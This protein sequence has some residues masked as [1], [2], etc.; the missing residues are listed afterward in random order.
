MFRETANSHSWYVAVRQPKAHAYVRNTHT[1]A[2]E[3]EARQFARERLADGCEVSAGTINP[4]SP[5]V[6][7]GSWQIAAWLGGE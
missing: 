1:F 7:I 4:H 2:T 5:K 3:A 6:T